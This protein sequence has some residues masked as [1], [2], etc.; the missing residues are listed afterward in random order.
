MQ[1]GGFPLRLASIAL[2]EDGLALR[3]EA[4]GSR[5]AMEP[6]MNFHKRDLVDN[7]PKNTEAFSLCF[8]S[9]NFIDYLLS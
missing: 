8:F 2:S 5:Q 9:E 1:T 6:M 3:R 4:E 7:K